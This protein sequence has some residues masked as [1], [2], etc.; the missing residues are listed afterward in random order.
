MPRIIRF[1]VDALRD[2]KAITQ[3]VGYAANDG[4]VWCALTNGTLWQVY[5]SVEKCPAPEKLMYEVSLDPR[6]AED[7]SVDQIAEQLWRLSRQEMASGTL[8]RRS[9]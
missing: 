3:V 2:V 7:M 4:V 6:D 9:R 5:R 1:I 8:T